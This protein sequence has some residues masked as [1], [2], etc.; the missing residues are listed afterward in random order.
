MSLLIQNLLVLVA[1]AWCVRF[2]FC[3]V[4]KTLSG[5]GGGSGCGGCTGCGAQ[6]EATKGQG[7]AT[8]EGRKVVFLPVDN[9]RVSKRL[10]K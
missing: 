3:R 8:K 5:G 10:A 7:E 4:K 9:L 1:V 2:V 6:V